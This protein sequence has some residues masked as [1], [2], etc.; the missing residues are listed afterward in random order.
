MGLFDLPDDAKERIDALIMVGSNIATGLTSLSK[1]VSKLRTA[2]EN[3]TKQAEQAER[4]C[5]CK[6]KKD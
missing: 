3:Q 2:V 1:E 5:A 4:N 6:T